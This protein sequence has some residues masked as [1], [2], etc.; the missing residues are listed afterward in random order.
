M[1]VALCLSGLTRSVKFSW[2]LIKRY[3]VEPYN[4]D[5][6]L[7]T[8]EDID[9]EGMRPRVNGGTDTPSFLLETKENFIMEEINP[10]TYKLEDWEDFKKRDGLHML[11]VRSMFYSIQAA[12]KLK[13]EHEE[14]NGIK[15][16]IVIRSRMDMFY[17][18]SLIESEV[19]D[20]LEN[21]VLYIQYAGNPKGW[22]KAG[23]NQMRF[24]DIFAFSTSQNMDIYS[25]TIKDL[26]IPSGEVAIT[27]SLN[28]NNI[29]TK[30]SKIRFK[31]AV[32]WTRN[33]LTITGLHL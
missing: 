9:N 16:D 20:V 18:Q 29:N 23:Y 19:T 2:P 31:S 6:F 32:K 4:S 11:D 15:Y 8:W 27:K 14:L 26:T 28:K 12:N 10:K 21:D 7:H 30:W 13:L 17:E 3:L 5:V 25:D 24:T 22:A 33:E 1:K